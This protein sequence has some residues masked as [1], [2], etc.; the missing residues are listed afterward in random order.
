MSNV[1]HAPAPIL[2]SQNFWLPPLSTADHNET[3]DLSSERASFIARINARL[4][5]DDFARQSVISLGQAIYDG[6]FVSLRKMVESYRHYPEQL[7]HLMYVLACDLRSEQVGILKIS[8]LDWRASGSEELHK[9]CV[10]T[11]RI[12][13]LR[14]LIDMSSDCNY[15]VTVFGLGNDAGNSTLTRLNENPIAIL[16]NVDLVPP[17][18]PVASAWWG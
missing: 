14:R 12:N 10:V 4:D 5:M 13:K 6:D 11:I 18:P 8:L 7:A 3:V 16:K 9:I 2:P 1:H 15:G 17:P